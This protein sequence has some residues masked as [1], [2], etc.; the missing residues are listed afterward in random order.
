[1]HQGH[2]A[3]EE[4]GLQIHS[5]LFMR[6]DRLTQ[7]LSVLHATHT[8]HCGASPGI[9]SAETLLAHTLVLPGVGKCKP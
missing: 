1:M 7:R 4:S 5:L 9:L 3:K 8:K 6:L 2:T